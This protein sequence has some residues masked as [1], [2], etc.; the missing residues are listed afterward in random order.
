MGHVLDGLVVKALIGEI[1][2]RTFVDV[3]LIG[4]IKT[5]S[6]SEIERISV[7]VGMAGIYTTTP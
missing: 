7:T 5:E 4:Y 1:S 3:I 2:V 6:G